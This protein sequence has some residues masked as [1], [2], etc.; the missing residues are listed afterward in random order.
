ADAGRQMAKARCQEIFELAERFCDPGKN[1]VI[2]LTRSTF[3]EKETTNLVIAPLSVA[4][5]MRS[6]IFDESTVVATSA[7]LSLG[8]NFDAVA[9][10]LG[11]FGPD[12]PKWDSLDVGSPFDYGRQGILYVASHLPRPGRS[13]MSPEALTELEELVRASDGGALGL[14]SSRAAATAA[15]E[16]LRETFDF[17][18][19]LQ[20][21][22]GLSSLVSQFTADD[23]ACLFGSMS[24]WQGVD[25][26]RSAWGRDAGHGAG[27]GFVPVSATHAALPLAPGAGRLIRSTGDRGVVAV[28]DARLRSARYAGF[29]V[30]SMPRMWP[31]TNS[32][33]VRTS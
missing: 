22:D 5:T 24:L 16:H 19:L 12:A 20:G 25:V 21:D 11:L 28:L 8:G 31:T 3:R 29:L 30:N 33:P 9:A 26:P 17:P 7:T 4:G 23:R 18:I 27:S 13:G 6:G 14:F 2:W 32:E 1:D 15:A 10:A